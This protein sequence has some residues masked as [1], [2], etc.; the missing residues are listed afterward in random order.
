[1]SSICCLLGDPYHLSPEPEKSIDIMTPDESGQSITQ[2]YS[3]CEME[4]S[5]V[6]GATFKFPGVYHILVQETYTISTKTLL[7]AHLS[8]SYYFFLDGANGSHT[9]WAP[10]SSKWRHNPFRYLYI[11]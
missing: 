11:A 5:E 2:L 6:N 10:T 3:W 9:R 7:K 1:M 8:R 4:R